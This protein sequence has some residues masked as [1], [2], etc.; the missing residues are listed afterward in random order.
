MFEWINN[1]LVVQKFILLIV[2]IIE[3]YEKLYKFFLIFYEK[4]L[5]P[6]FEYVLTIIC[7]RILSLYLL[8]IEQIH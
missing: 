2:P 3:Y 4:L 7:L 5:T 1:M 6:Q 8:R